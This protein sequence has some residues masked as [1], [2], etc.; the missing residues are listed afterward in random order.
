M[1]DDIDV[2]KNWEVLGR[3]WHVFS[4]LGH[5]TWIATQVASSSSSTSDWEASEG[6]MAITKLD[7]PEV[8]SDWVD[9]LASAAKVFLLV[10]VI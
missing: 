1:V 8:I 9:T 3:K 7:P 5:A 4:F 2:W 6:A 10:H